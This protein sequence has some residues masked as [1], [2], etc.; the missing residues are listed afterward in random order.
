VNRRQ[1]TAYHEA[2]HAVLA[3]HSRF[4]SQSGRIHLKAE[5]GGVI[6]ISVDREKLN[7]FQVGRSGFEDPLPAM[8]E[9]HAVILC[10]GVVGAAIAW[11]VDLIQ[12]RIPRN[13]GSDHAIAASE[14][15]AAGLPDDL[16][17]YHARAREALEREWWAVEKIAAFLFTTEDADAEVVREMIENWEGESA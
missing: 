8:A 15:K 12:S 9:D 17:P 10:G 13:P 7:A 4:Y 11:K 3:Y 2:A 1:I 14:L 16:E 5:G 6:R